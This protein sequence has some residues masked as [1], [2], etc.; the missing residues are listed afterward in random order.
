MGEKHIEVRK[1]GYRKNENWL[2]SRSWE[3]DLGGLYP[4]YPL[5]G[6]TR[7]DLACKN[8]RVKLRLCLMRKGSTQLWPGGSVGWTIVSY[9]KRWFDS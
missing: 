1:M 7:G 5:H 3:N 4:S 2:E 9:T 6:L 8:H